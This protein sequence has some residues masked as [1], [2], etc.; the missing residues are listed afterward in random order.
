MY[1]RY[2][3]TR[4]NCSKGEGYG[5]GEEREEEN[6]KRKDKMETKEVKRD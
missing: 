3:E 5:G 2:Y 4:R 6:E 1:N